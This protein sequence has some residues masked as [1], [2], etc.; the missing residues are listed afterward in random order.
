LSDVLD[1]WGDGEHLALG[2][3]LAL[4]VLTLPFFLRSGYAARAVLFL[5]ITTAV[6]MYV[7]SMLFFDR[8][9][10]EYHFRTTWEWN[11][12]PVFLY[13]MTLAYFATYYVVMQIALRALRAEQP[14][15]RRFTSILVLGYLV[16]F[17]ETAFMATPALAKHFVYRDKVFM[18]VFGSWCYGSVFFATLPGF[19][20]LTRSQ[21]P[22]RVVGVAVLG[23]AIALSLYLVYAYLLPSLPRF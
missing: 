8:L 17:G 12:S 5:V 4:P 2:I 7:G 18:L 15:R 19:L 23:N 21:P 20:G 22:A 9:G 16:A 13:P 11:R 14:G 1:R 6:Q 3:G 10:M